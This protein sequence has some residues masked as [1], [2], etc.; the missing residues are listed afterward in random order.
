VSPLRILEVCGAADGGG[1]F[2]D[3]VLELT[4]RGHQVECVVPGPGSVAERLRAH[5]V[6]VRELPFRGYAPRD[7]PRVLRA[8][9]RLRKLAFGGDFD[10][11]HAHLLKSIVLCRV[12][13]RGRGPALVSQ[14]ANVVHLGSRPLTWI[15]TVTMRWDSLLL[16]SC[17]DF[18]QRYRALGAT[19]TAVSFYGCDVDRLDPDATPDP[20]RAE[21]ALDVG[22]V[23]VGM[24]AHMY[25]TRLAQ[26][27]D[28]GVKGHET[29]I[30]AA[31]IIS[32]AHPEVRFVVVGDEF[33]GD[34]AYRR[35]LERRAADLVA[36]GVLTFL[37]HREDMESVL[38]G[39]DVLVNPS[40]SESA[41]YTM[42]E[43][44]LMRRPVVASAVGGLLDTVRQEE[45]GILVPPAD[46]AA[47]A[48]AITRL[49]E[50]PTLRRTFGVAGRA[51]VRRLFALEATVD[52][53]ESAY[54][55]VLGAAR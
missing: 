22:M 31:R 24:V 12:A 35:S 47:L 26:F 16:A 50:D 3:Q 46:V 14:V 6:R 32:D 21:Q 41:S 10:I 29:F 49:V 20:F 13:L 33:A 28:V 27:A 17:T 36:R 7:V 40:L 51:H 43:A 5:G 23:A 44:S 55:R 37:G 25:P 4:R 48:A 30:D 54:A 38:A 11:V 19:A 53:V 15:D 2:V 52:S 18:E 8:T 9:R 1:W 42:I 34:G 39:L 45:T